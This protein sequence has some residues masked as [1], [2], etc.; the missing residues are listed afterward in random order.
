MIVRRKEVHEQQFTDDTILLAKTLAMF[1]G[2]SVNCSQIM[3][4]LRFPSQRLIKFWTVTFRPLQIST[5]ELQI[6]KCT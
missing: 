2:L 5:S 1:I 4:F 6:I 3:E